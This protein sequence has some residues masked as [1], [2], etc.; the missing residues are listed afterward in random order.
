[1]VVLSREEELVCEIK[2]ERLQKR[3]EGRE[4]AEE[5]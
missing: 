2:N 4:V 1:M 5:R 3:A